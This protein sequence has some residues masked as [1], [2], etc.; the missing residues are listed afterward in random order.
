MPR[1][2]PPEGGPVRHW[3]L[4]RAAP[5]S[6]VRASTGVTDARTRRPSFISTSTSTVPRYGSHLTRRL[7]CA[8][9]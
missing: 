7:R 8:A 2:G 4:S 1:G 3:T 5:G 6:T 9:A